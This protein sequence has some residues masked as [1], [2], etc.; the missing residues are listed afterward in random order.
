LRTTLPSFAAFAC[1][2]FCAQ[3]YG[4]DSGLSASYTG[5]HT[6]NVRESSADPQS[7]WIN[8]IGASANLYQEV[9][10]FDAA[11]SYYVER[12]IYSGSDYP[13]ETLGNG[14]AS[15]RWTP[16][17]DRVS[18][19]AT[20]TLTRSTIDI[21]VPETPNNQQNVSYTDLG[22]ELSLP[23]L[24]HQSLFAG[25]HY[26]ITNASRSD[27]DSDRYG[28]N[29]GY[30]MELSPTREISVSGAYNEVDFANPLSIDYSSVTGSVDL[31][32]TTRLLS[33]FLSAGYTSIDRV[34]FA[35]KLDGFVGGMNATWFIRES[36]S[37]E[38]T[39]RQ[40][41]RDNYDPGR[42]VSDLGGLQ[43]APAVE[44]ATDDQIYDPAI[45]PTES[46]SVYRERVLAVA[47]S[48]SGARSRLSVGVSYSAR[49]YELES[50]NDRQARAV[51][52]YG[53]SLGRT[54]ELTLD[55]SYEHLDFLVDDRNDEVIR[56]GIGY[57]F[58]PL[59]RLTTA[60]R[61]RYR[62]RMSDIDT[63]AYNNWRFLV[64]LSYRLL[65]TY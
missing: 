49:K 8:H 47:Y 52:S 53:W 42:S 34:G 55:A 50:R 14:N 46:T 54:G 16:V 57:S 2:S 41:V 27:T 13:D 6:D 65:P 44:E 62:E 59:N 38:L 10:Q 25:A 64:T 39:L 29:V 48:Q 56:A 15:L 45:E 31:S 3:V 21:R 7:A 5:E 30:R 12:R 36:S 22:T 28:G 20:N 19:Y 63:F 33:L 17:T 32:S 9:A 23:V 4:L 40:D 11:A 61:V 1:L 43:Q 58:E 51:A 18:L 37:L 35:K 60:F 24:S 26:G